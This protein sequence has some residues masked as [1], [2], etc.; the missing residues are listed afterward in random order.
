MNHDKSIEK[1]LSLFDNTNKGGD[2]LIQIVAKKSVE[3][4][5][6]RKEKLNISDIDYEVYIYGM[7]IFI[8]TILSIIMLWMIGQALTQYLNR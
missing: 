4:L 2:F 3:Y 7:E 1:S 8:S 5:M 6:D